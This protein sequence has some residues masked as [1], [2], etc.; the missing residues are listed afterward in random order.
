MEQKNASGRPHLTDAPQDLATG[1]GTLF[2]RLSTIIERIDRTLDA[3]G[4][5]GGPAA[6]RGDIRPASA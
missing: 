5:E 3:R 2:D 4:S 1:L 6:A